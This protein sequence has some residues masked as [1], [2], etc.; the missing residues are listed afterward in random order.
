M[1]AKTTVTIAA[2]N[3]SGGPDQFRTIDVRLV[4]GGAGGTVD[5]LAI[6]DEFRVRLDDDGEGTIDLYPNSAITPAGTYYLFT[7]K[8][9]TPAVVRAVTVPTSGPVDWTDDEIQ[10]E[11]PSPPVIVPAP[12]S[13]DAFDVIHV[14]EEGLRYTLGQ[15][16]HYFLS[17]LD[18]GNQ[19]P[20]SAIEGLQDALDAAGT[21]ARKVGVFLESLNASGGG[22]TDV[23]FY[24]STLTIPRSAITGIPVFVA[25]GP[26]KGP[27]TM[28]A[29]G[30]CTAI[31]ASPADIFVPVGGGAAFRAQAVSSDGVTI[32][33]WTV[34]A[35]GFSPPQNIRAL[36]V[37]Q[38]EATT[39]PSQ[40][41]ECGFGLDSG[42]PERGYWSNTT[43]MA[44]FTDRMVTRAWVRCLSGDG[45]AE[46]YQE[47]HSEALDGGGVP[48]AGG[49]WDRFED[50]LRLESDTVKWFAEETKTGGTQEWWKANGYPIFAEG[51]IPVG[52]WVELLHD[53]GAD[54]FDY[55]RI[56]TDVSWDHTE[57]DGSTWRTIGVQDKRGTFT[58][59]ASN[60]VA[61][62]VGRGGGRFDV[63]RVRAWVDG[64]LEVDFDPSTV[65]VGATAIPDGV[66]GTWNAA[67]N[68]VVGGGDSGD[69][70]PS[71]RTLAGLD[72]TQDRS[73]S[74]LRTA[75]SLVPGTDIQAY[76]ADLA[77]IAA[78]S[79]T[80]FGRNLLALV[81]AAALRAASGGWQIIGRRTL[82]STSAN[83][84]F[85]ITGYKL[86]RVTI[87]GRNTA[88]GNATQGIRQRFNGDTG[89]TYSASGGALQAYT[90]CGTLPGSQTNTDRSGYV[91]IRWA[92]A[93]GHWL[94]GAW[95]N[96]ATSSTGTTGVN[97]STGSI[98]WT[99]AASAA[100][101][102]T[103]FY[104]G[105]GGFAAGTEFLVEGHA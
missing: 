78:I 47:T 2:V 53:R 37:A 90:S 96:V 45:T 51:E 75:L 89:N 82:A 83:E 98:T 74:T 88:T 7:A 41:A 9:V 34:E 36:L 85:T 97:T 71:S 11:D 42:D 92:Y 93:A 32:S 73:A 104:F 30:P 61:Q 23:T 24:G 87:I 50:G 57:P 86:I 29:S 56:R 76:D 59:A 5:G 31:T 38:A 101:T 14:D 4:H 55:K 105:S 18:A 99:G 43:R 102:T 77:A 10:V 1:T 79:T 60:A 33:D 66:A 3:A 16:P 52:V 68:A 21:S 81:D 72:L 28:T 13:G 80:S 94:T 91:Q 35:V 49:D 95:S 64:D 63:A 100:P 15:L 69:A 40:W 62:W 17:G 48:G 39:A 103:E 6:T 54:G 46:L 12:Q 67:L 65:T 27:W 25:E 22:F 84:S 70:V 19:H 8:G 20:I 44:S 58:M 26:D